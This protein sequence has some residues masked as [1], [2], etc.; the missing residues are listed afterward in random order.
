MC[1]R[2]STAGKRLF[3]LHIMCQQSLLDVWSSEDEDDII[4]SDEEDEHNAW[5]LFLEVVR[6]CRWGGFFGDEEGVCEDS[7]ERSSFNGY[8]V[9][10]DVRCLTV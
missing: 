7:S 2:N 10:G 3:W 8:R 9:P 6:A 1:G 4:S 5:N